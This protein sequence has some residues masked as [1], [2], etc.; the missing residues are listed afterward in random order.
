MFEREYLAVFLLPQLY[1]IESLI[2]KDLM[3][4]EKEASDDVNREHFLG[5]G[6]YPSSWFGSIDPMV[7]EVAYFD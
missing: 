2:A 6:P 5:C 7:S 3:L 1:K 4:V